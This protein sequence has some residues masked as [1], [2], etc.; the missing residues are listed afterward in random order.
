M[1]TPNTDKTELETNIVNKQG[2]ELPSTGGIGTTIFYV[3]GGI[4][5]AGAAIALITKKRMGS[6]K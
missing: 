1:F 6:E 5:V 2:I 3:I 4:M